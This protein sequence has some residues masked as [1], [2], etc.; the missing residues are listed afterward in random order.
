VGRIF[1]RLDR[2][3]EVS[4]AIAVAVADV[5]FRRGLTKKSRP[6]DL[7]AHIKALMY[8]PVYVDYVPTF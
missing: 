8:D 2:I 4:I 3:R 1:P 6:P 5:A 7:A